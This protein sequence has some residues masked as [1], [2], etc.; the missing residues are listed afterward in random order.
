MKKDNQSLFLYTF[1]TVFGGLIVGLNMAGISGGIPFIQD[2][3]GLNDMSLGLVVGILTIGCLFGAL[4]GGRFS[5][6]YGRRKVM[7][8][9]A[10]LFIISSLGCAL[11]PNAAGLM[12]FRFISGFGVGMISAVAPVYISEISPAK[13]RG[14]LVSYNQLA[15][16]IG[17][18]IAYVIDYILLN[19]ENN[20]RMMLGFPFIFSVI[21]LLL[22]SILP[23]S[24]RWLYTQN[25]KDKASQVIDKL[26][27]DKS[28]FGNLA[29]SATQADQKV[30]I[31]DL[32]RGK[33]A[34]V[35]L[36]GSL[37]AAL[38]QITG[39]NV[40]INYAP[41]IFEMTGVAGDIALVQSIYVGIVNLIFTL[42]AVWLVDKVGRKILLLCGSLGMAVS[43]AYLVYTFL[44][45]SANGI[46]SL[47]AVLFY[48]GFFAASL[49]P[50]MWV[51]TSEIYPSRIRGTAMSLSTGIS[52]LCTFLTVQFFPWILN[53]LGGSVAF[54][55]FA[56][57]SLIAFVFIWICIPETKGKSLEKI[58]YELGLSKER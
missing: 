27:L 46:G 7:F 2:Q 16:V 13:L 53:N 54:G 33:L 45:P 38:Q 35:V 55:I 50:V 37:L 5:D 52:W 57:F 23:E 8:F 15:V 12:V 6:K 36:I 18:L 9:S 20:W 40:I 39:I 17:I 4:L 49:A 43:L 1:I 25:K 26:S 11:S 22:L 41:T 44:V 48:I 51:V 56:I 29:L 3:F 47:I 30:R 14:T 34:K 42:I 10:F 24:P 21:Y 28:E 19:Y 31:S 58:E 32:F